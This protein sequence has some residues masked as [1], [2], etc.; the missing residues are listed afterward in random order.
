MVAKINFH[1]VTSYPKNNFHILMS[2][3]RLQGRKKSFVDFL[4]YLLRQIDE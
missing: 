1:A 3:G 4:A 2:G